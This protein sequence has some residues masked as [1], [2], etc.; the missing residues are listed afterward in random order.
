MNVEDMQYNFTTNTDR[1]IQLLQLVA[2]RQRI[3]VFDIVEE[4]AVS[5]STARRDLEILARQGRVQRVHGGTFAIQSTQP[6][7][8]LLERGNERDAEKRRIGQ[9]AAALVREGE[10]IFRRTTPAHHDG[11]SSFL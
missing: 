3:A 10:T 7:L 1:Q 2:Q 6:E 8:P 11:Y 9:A 4:F 5:E